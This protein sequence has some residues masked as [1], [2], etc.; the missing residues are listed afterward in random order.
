MAR[1]VVKIAFMLLSGLIIASLLSFMLIS[2]QWIKIN[3][4]KLN[5]LE[6]KLE[7]DFQLFTG[8]TVDQ[9]KQTTTAQPN[10]ISANVKL[11]RLTKTTTTLTTTVKTT[12]Q[13]TTAESEHDNLTD[14]DG[15]EQ[16]DT[17]QNADDSENLDYEQESDAKRHKRS[18]E[19][20]VDYVYLTKLWPFVKYKSLYS[21]CI[22][23]KK[24]NLKISSAFLTQPNKEPLLGTVSYG[25]L[26]NQLTNNS[27]IHC[28]K[29][30]MIK[31]LVSQQCVQGKL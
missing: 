6:K 18:D 8:P 27:Q 31:C 28:E 12:T 24:V 30:G 5:D 11:N 2:D 26:I 13:T 10:L 4:E 20:V 14:Q 1:H 21:E 25:K 16:E 15:E 3:T 19:Q 9:V 22:E 17:D 29:P 23:Y 7:T